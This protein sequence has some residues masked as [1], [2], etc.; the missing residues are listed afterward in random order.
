MSDDSEFGQECHTRERKKY[1]FLEV[2][3]IK[4]AFVFNG[5]E[6]MGRIKCD[7]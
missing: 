3:P 5:S 6:Q 1:A 7:P 4:S 2:E